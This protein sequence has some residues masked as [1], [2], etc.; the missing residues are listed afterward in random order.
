M[1]M[2]RVENNALFVA[3]RERERVRQF[4]LLTFFFFVLF[5]SSERSEVFLFVV[6]THKKRSFYLLF[7][8]T[9]L[10]HQKTEAKNEK[11]T[12]G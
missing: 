4:V 2:S 7:F 8:P 1:M 11:T 6:E 9:T 12:R 10:F 3:K 5:F